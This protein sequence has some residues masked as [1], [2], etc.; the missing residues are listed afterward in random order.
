MS[1]VDIARWRAAV[2]E[3]FVNTMGSARWGPGAALAREYYAGQGSPR[4]LRTD[5]EGCLVGPPVTFK[6][7][8]HLLEMREITAVLSVHCVAGDCSRHP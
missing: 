4:I 7:L 5:R 8:G 2:D 1:A 3:Y 6:M